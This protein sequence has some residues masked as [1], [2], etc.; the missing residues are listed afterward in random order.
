MKRNYILFFIV[1]FGIVQLGVSQKKPAYQLYKANGKKT[2]YKH[3]LKNAPKTQIILFG[4]FHNNP[5]SH[6]LQLE[7]IQ[8]LHANDIPL[9]LGAEMFEADNQSQLNQY[10]SGKLDAKQ[11]AEQA[12]LWNNYTTD[13]AP[14]VDF[15]KANQ[16]AFTATNIPRRF[17][18]K[19]YKE[20]GFSA[21]D[22]LSDEE[23]TWIPP[24][25]IPFDSQLKTYQDMLSM[26]GEHATEDILKAQAIKDASMAYFILNNLEKDKLFI[27]FN[28]SYHSNFYEGIFWYL[29][30]YQKDI[31]IMTITTVEQEDITALEEVNKNAADYIICVP[32]TMTKTY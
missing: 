25:P 31:E 5:I 16:I 15:A 30:T 14:L 29:K 4:E 2:N 20:G 21:L 1:C 28:G 8:D 17:A 23:K 12:R 32:S 19:V 26:M 10:L 7:L 3:L 24:L 18:S 6:W 11:L 22:S 9:S 27:H 13:Y